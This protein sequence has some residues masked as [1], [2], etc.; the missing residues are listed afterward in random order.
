MNTVMSSQIV[1]MNTNT[2]MA[3]TRKLRNVKPSL[4]NSIAIL[5]VSDAQNARSPACSS[6]RAPQPS[7]AGGSPMR[8]PFLL[9]H[10]SIGILLLCTRKPLKLYRFHIGDHYGK[11]KSIRNV[12]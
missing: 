6:F 5:H 10:Y 9:E 4:T 7:G 3:S 12:R 2:V 11:G 1:T 8:A